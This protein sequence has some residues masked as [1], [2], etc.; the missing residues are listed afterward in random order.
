MKCVVASCSL[1]TSERK[2]Y[3]GAVAFFPGGLD[4]TSCSSVSPQTL[5]SFPKTEIPITIRMHNLVGLVAFLFMHTDS[6]EFDSSP[7]SI[8]L[9]SSLHILASAYGAIGGYSTQTDS[10][11]ISGYITLSNAWRDYYTVG[12][13]NLWLESNAAGGKYY[14][15]NLVTARASWLLPGERVALAAH[16]A[17]LNEGE[18][19]FYSNPTVFHWAGG[20]ATYWFSPFQFAMT[21]F[22]LSLSG[23]TLVAGA[24]RGTFSFNVA[25]GIWSTSTVIVNDAD[26]TARLCSFRQS[27]SVPLGN[28]SFLVASGEIGRR[29]FYFDDEALVIYNQRSVQT[30]LFILKGTVQTFDRLYLIPSFEY[31]SFDGYNVKYGSLGIRIVF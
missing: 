7:A 14:S 26:F 19:Q 31:N 18:I 23:G 4:F 24:Y 17:Y 20:G 21:S 9:P 12:Y 16:Y 25:D 11:S 1:A 30:G 10:R 2:T 29:G 28:E 13:S 5:P 6:T 8:S 3:L 22:S 27:V 15:Q